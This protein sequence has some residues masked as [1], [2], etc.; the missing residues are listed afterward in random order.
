MQFMA[1]M[2]PA[3]LFARF[4][5]S[6]AGKKR[7]DTARLY[8]FTNEKGGMHGFDRDLQLKVIAELSAGSAH[9]G[10]A[11]EM[12]RRTTERI[13]SIRKQL[14]RRRTPR[15]ACARSKQTGT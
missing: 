4:A 10:R 8:V 12:D 3:R 7:G 5:S 14:K 2:Q 13:E 1:R 9:E 6:K 15:R 11:L